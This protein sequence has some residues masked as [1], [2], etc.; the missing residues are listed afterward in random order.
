MF[1]SEIAWPI[2]PK[3]SR[4][5]D[6][7]SKLYK[8]PSIDASSQV[9]DHLANRFQRRRILEIDKSKTRIG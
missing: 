6:G 8:E 3:L 2:E 9:S 5:R 1:S 4:D 7:L